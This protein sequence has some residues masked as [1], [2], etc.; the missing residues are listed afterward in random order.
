MAS[1]DLIVSFA[2][3]ARHASFAKA[4]R[5]LALSPSA[6]AKNIARLETQLGVRL[7]HRT[8]RQMTLSQDGED[9]FVR[10]LRILEEVESLEGSI[11]ESR[12]G[13]S[14][15]LRIDVPV[16]YGRLIVLPVLMKLIAN[17]PA[18]KV[19]VRFSDNGL[20][21]SKKG[22]TR[23]CELGRLPTRA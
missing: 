20:M 21:S 16:V 1:L 2:A 18:L 17:T 22:L 7:F 19:D 11:T 5:E 8:T 12:N 13:L 10:C 14:G 6:V 23:R 3:A 15:T 9:I 4:A